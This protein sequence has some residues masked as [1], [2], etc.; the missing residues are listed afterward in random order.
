[1]QSNTISDMRYELDVK[2][3]LAINHFSLICLFLREFW[4]ILRKFLSKI[5][6]FFGKKNYFHSKRTDL[7]IN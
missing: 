1:M 5:K 6:V 7:L 2:I 4:L 3:M